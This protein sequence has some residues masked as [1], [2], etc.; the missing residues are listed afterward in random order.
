[1]TFTQPGFMLA[2]SIPSNSDS[3]TYSNI[4][5]PE[6]GY[7]KRFEST[8]NILQFSRSKEKSKN[9]RATTEP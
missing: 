9:K 2:L 5:T 3:L 1:M 7:F 4:D 8:H 6:A